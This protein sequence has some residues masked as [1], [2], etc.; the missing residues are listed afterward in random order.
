MERKNI[1]EV[2]GKAIELLQKE[3][4]PLSIGYVA[5]HL[6]ITWQTARGLLLKMALLQ[7]IKAQPTSKGFMFCLI[8][9]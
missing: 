5:Y 9:N 3:K 1:E 2:E 8:D 6:G 7:K 4:M